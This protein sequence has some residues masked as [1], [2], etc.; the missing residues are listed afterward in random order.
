MPK[1]NKPNKEEMRTKALELVNAYFDDK[2]IVMKDP[3]SGVEFWMSIRHPKC[4]S[5]LGLFCENAEKYRIMD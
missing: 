1:N 4:K 3:D 2:D 5:F